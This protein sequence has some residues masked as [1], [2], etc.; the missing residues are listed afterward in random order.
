VN[1]R[2]G[3]STRRAA[4]KPASGAPAPVISS[5]S[6]SSGERW[7]ASTSMTLSGSNFDAG[8][9]VNFGASSNISATYSAGVLSFTVPESEFYETGTKN[10]TVTYNGQTSNA[11][12]FTVS[13]P[14]ILIQDLRADRGITLNGS[15]VS[16]WSSSDT[17]GDSNRTV[18]QATASLQPTFQSSDSNFN[19]K[20]SVK[21]TK[22][23]A[24]RLV[25][26]AFSTGN[27]AQTTYAGVIKSDQSGNGA[28][29]LADGLTSGTRSFV[30]SYNNFSASTGFFMY[31]GGS[32]ETFALSTVTTASAIF[33]QFEGSVG[34]ATTERIYVRSASSGTSATKGTNNGQTGLTLGDRFAAYT[35]DGAGSWEGAVAEWLM[36]NAPL[37]EAQ[38]TRLGNY[39]GNRYGSGVMTP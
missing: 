14:S 13:Q 24:T 6:A 32:T 1:R 35:T 5:L 8:A 23:N 15:K 10:V 30:G 20:P 34:G 36:F 7:F 25:S 26:G 12:T 11:L 22:A 4:R 16:A 33:T 3:L 17:S 18:S 27:W 2:P 31:R 39:F 29:W 21:F 19:N 9:V 37:T 38:R 28:W